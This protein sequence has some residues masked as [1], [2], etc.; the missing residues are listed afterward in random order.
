MA[1]KQS[2]IIFPLVAYI[3]H[4]LERTSPKRVLLSNCW[5]QKVPAEFAI[6][7]WTSCCS[8]FHD[9]RW[10]YNGY[11]ISSLSMSGYPSPPHSLQPFPPLPVAA[12]RWL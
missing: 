2:H 1:G 8:D 7:W 3:S 5:W 9:W 4:D 10:G 12:L 6:T 11:S